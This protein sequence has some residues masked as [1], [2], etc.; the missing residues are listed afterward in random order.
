MALFA[1]VS[2]GV[3]YSADRLL[4][5]KPLDGSVPI[6]VNEVKQVEGGLKWRQGGFSSFVTL[7]DAR[8]KESNFEATTQTFTNNS[9]KADGVEFEMGWRVGA[10]RVNG[11]ATYTHARITATA[12]GS[13]VGNTPRR[14]ANLTYQFSPSYTA[15]AWEV[16]AA[17]VGT[18]KSYGDDANTITLP[19]FVV[20][21]PYVSWQ[22]S[23]NVSVS[24][25][26]NNA[27]N[28]IGYTEIE[29]D[30]HAARS[31]DGRTLRATLKYSF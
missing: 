20:V 18:T 21:N 12:D 11:G 19:A 22:A 8:T 28:T 9:Y 1:R 26:A 31:I 14:Q 3:A 5:G 2:D 25:S 29:S 15:G 10:F 30:G 24:L 17:I 6:D 13:D 4:Y 7:F 27:F 16:G 23:D